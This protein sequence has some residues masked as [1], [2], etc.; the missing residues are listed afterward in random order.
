MKLQFGV[1]VY[2]IPGK[3][4]DKLLKFV[5]NNNFKA[6]ELWDHPLPKM[7]TWQA[8]MIERSNID[9]SVHAP[10]LDLGK[11]NLIEKNTNSLRESIDKASEWRASKV[12]VHAGQVCEEDFDT[13]VGAVK[14][15][16]SSVLPILEDRSISLCIENVGYQKNELL[17]NFVQLF[18]LVVDFP[19]K[20]VGVAYDVSHANVTGDI[21]EGVEILGPRINH[22]H[23][24]DNLGEINNHHLPIGKGEIDFTKIL[25]LIKLNSA[26]FEIRPTENWK[27]NILSSKEI[28]KKITCADLGR[29]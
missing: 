7:S 3:S 23:L 2:S 9:I 18:D 27:S 16:I 8:K 24:S 4:I 17:T 21:S 5:D 25:D 28:I 20:L 15:T 10:L 26:I 12:I 13:A 22:I 6:V 11:V 1:S 29:M 19:K 14:E